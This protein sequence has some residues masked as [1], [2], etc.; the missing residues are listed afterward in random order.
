MI[1]VCCSVSL[2]S[3]T[4]IICPH[5][6]AVWMAGVDIAASILWR[7]DSLTA[8][9]LANSSCV[10]FLFSLV[11]LSIA[12]ISSTTSSVVSGGVGCEYRGFRFEVASFKFGG[13]NTFPYVEHF[14]HTVIVTPS[15]CALT[16]VPFT[17]HISQM[18]MGL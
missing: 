15:I 18:V 12:P 17:P 5:F 9:F 2:T 13:V 8:N 16:S 7:N 11:C 14:S 4:P 6:F 3:C 10:I 1:P